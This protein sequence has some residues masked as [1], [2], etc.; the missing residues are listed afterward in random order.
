ME[1]RLYHRAY[2]PTLGGVAVPKDRLINDL[3]DRATDYIGTFSEYN[4]IGFV[5]PLLAV[6]VKDTCTHFPQKAF[7][8]PG[9]NL[10][11]GMGYHGS[12]FN[13]NY[14][15]KFSKQDLLRIAHAMDET[16]YLHILSADSVDTDFI[17]EQ[18][19]KVT[20]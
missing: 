1:H 14:S 12:R 8:L 19:N 20:T 10:K 17:R 9:F 4:P 6:V 7:I 18:V 15:I 2:K 3:E 11:H 5:N 16:D 13:N